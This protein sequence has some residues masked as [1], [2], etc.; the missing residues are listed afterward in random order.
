MSDEEITVN[1][2]LPSYQALERAG[3]IPKLGMPL[4]PTLIS[5]VFPLFITMAAMP[6][7]QIKAYLIMLICIPTLGFIWAATKDDDQALTIMGY[8]LKWLLMRRNY[9][10]FGKTN[11]ILATKYGR[12]KD[13]YAQFFEKINGK[14][15]QYEYKPYE[16]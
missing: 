7:L 12:Q 5:I 3:L 15:E 9:Y 16:R 1:T 4:V 10:L 11:T 14:T 6:F 8:T 13:D 2:P